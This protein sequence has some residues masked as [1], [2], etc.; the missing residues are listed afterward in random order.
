MNDIN[1]V[2]PKFNLILYADDTTMISYMCTFTSVLRQDTVCIADD[3]NEEYSRMSDWLAVRKLP[4]NVSKITFIQFHQRQKIVN[5]SDYL[6]LRIND[7]EIERVH[8]FNFWASSYM[9]ILIGPVIVI[10]LSL[11]FPEPWE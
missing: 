4:L 5:E 10:I 6:K 1:A 11:K 7:S 9:N 8:E 3:I 2:G